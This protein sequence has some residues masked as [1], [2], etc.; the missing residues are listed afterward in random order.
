MHLFPMNAHKMTSLLVA[1]LLA[2]GRL[3]AHEALAGTPHI[4]PHEHPEF[5]NVTTTFT[6]DDDTKV[7]WSPVP[8]SRG[9]YL[10]TVSQ[11]VTGKEKIY[12]LLTLGLQ[13]IT[14]DQQVTLI[15]G[16]GT[17]LHYQHNNPTGSP[18]LAG[19]L[20]GKTGL[21]ATNDHLDKD[22]IEFISFSEER[23]VLLV[24]VGLPA[25]LGATKWAGMP[26]SKSGHDNTP[27]D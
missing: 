4:P 13:S 9:S 21:N 1:L 26:S 23:C 2:T 19:Q 8:G 3:A 11:I 25:A 12:S 10:V 5:V 24:K 22:K 20:I 18:W 7:S 14:K 16:G 27:P 15:S 17:V 6:F